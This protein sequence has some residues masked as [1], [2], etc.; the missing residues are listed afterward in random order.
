MAFH[1]NEIQ[2]FST[3]AA[4][5]PPSVEMTHLGEGHSYLE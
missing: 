3:S 2:D 1:P 4:R 5:A